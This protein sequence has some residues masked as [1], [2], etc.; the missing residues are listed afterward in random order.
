MSFLKLVGATVVTTGVA[1]CAYFF[2]EEQGK[3]Q[4]Q[5]QGFKEGVKTG[6]AETTKKYEQKMRELLQRF[7]FYNDFD[8]T[9]VACYAVG[10][11]A[12]STDGEISKENR[13]ELDSFISGILSGNIPEHIKSVINELTKKPPTLEVALKFAKDAKLPKRDIDDI[14][15]MIVTVGGEVGQKQRQF[16]SEWQSL[17]DNYQVEIEV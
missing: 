8:S 16:I 12:A 6:N 13:E 2:G 9:I 14:I 7:S 17:S 15:D 3:K 10:L 1:A 11:A 5:E 4:G